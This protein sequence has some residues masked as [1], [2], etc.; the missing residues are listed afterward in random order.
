MNR[1]MKTMSCYFIE[2]LKTLT[3]RRTTKTNSATNVL[4]YA[5]D[6]GMLSMNRNRQEDPDR[7]RWRNDLPF[8]NAQKFRTWKLRRRRR[9]MS[10]ASPSPPELPL[11]W[12]LQLYLS[13]QYDQIEEVYQAFYY[14]DRKYGVLSASYAQPQSGCLIPLSTT[15]YYPIPTI[16][17]TNYCRLH[18]DNFNITISVVSALSWYKLFYL[19]STNSCY[20]NLSLSPCWPRPMQPAALSCQWTSSTLC[21][22]IIAGLYN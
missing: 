9:L 14:E 19:L 1:E 3:K 7:R 18:Y 21:Q 4:S 5:D 17:L 22:W 8:K 6:R 2:W 13:H 11:R 10:K 16:I 15:Y 12:G 20:R